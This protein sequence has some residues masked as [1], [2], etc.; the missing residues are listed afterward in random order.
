MLLQ[1]LQLDRV[2]LRV[3]VAPDKRVERLPAEQGSGLL[4]VASEG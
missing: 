3:E 4:R 2:Q 1:R